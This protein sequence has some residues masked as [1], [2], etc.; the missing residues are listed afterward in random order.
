MNHDRP[1][2][3]PSACA[4]TDTR[5]FTC[6]LCNGDGGWDH[7]TGHDPQGPVWRW[8]TCDGCEGR[9]KIEV[10]SEPVTM[11]DLQDG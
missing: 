7:V 10:E 9:G 2:N 3:E 4:E 1:C 5:Q 6:G 11:E 8:Q